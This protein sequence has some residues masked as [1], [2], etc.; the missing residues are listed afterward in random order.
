MPTRLSMACLIGAGALVLVSSREASTS[1]TEKKP[2]A[3]DAAAMEDLA[4]LGAGFLVWE[5][6]VGGCW[7]IWTRSL[8]G[9]TPESRLVSEEE[10]KDHFCPKISPD[11]KRMAYMSYAS[12][13]TP[14]DPVEGALWLIDLHTQKRKLLAERARSYQGDR[15]VLWVDAVTLCHIDERG[16]SIELNVE[17]GE[18]S[19]LTT[20]ARAKNGWLVNAQR[21]HATSGDA[22]FSTFDAKSGEVRVLPKHS[23]CQPYFSADGRWGF[24]MG[25][26]GGP[27]N[28]IFLPTRRVEPV[29][30]HND[31]RLP[32]DRNYVYFPMLSPCQRLMAF[33]ASSD[34]HDHYESDYDIFVIRVDRE[35]LEPIGAAVRYTSHPGNDRYP[36]VYCAELPLG[37][38]H[39][40]A[41]ARIRMKSPSGQSCA[42]FVDGV[43]VGVGSEMDH[44]FTAPG[45]HWMEARD[46]NTG[47]ELGRGFVQVRAATAPK[48]TLARRV[49]GDALALTFDQAVSL[50]QATATTENGKSIPFGAQHAER[51]G[52]LLPLTNAVQ[53]GSR[54]TLE[55]VRDLAQ[56]PNVMPR[57]SFTVPTTGWPQS[58]MGL[59]YA[60][61]HR[62]ALPMALTDA[63]PVRTG[64]AFWNMR[65]GMDV[66]GGAFEIPGAG[67]AMLHAC[68]K[69]G[70]FTLEAIITPMVPPYDREA[71]PVLSLEDSQGNVK[72]AILQ[73][74]SDWSLWLATEDNPRGTSIEQELL[75]LRTGQPHHVVVA[76]VQG[77]LQVCLNG[78][79]MSVPS[80]VHGALKFDTE[81]GV[82]RIGACSKLQNRW[83]GMVDQLSIYHRVLSPD[84]A[85]A[86]ADHAAQKL[87]VQR[88]ARTRKVVAR[89]VQSS[90]LPSLAEVA[91]YR[92]ALV[93][94]LYEVLPKDKD[95]RD[96]DFPVGSRI[97]VTQWVWVNGEAVHVPVAKDG[98]YRLF[99]QP[100]EMHREIQPLVIKSDLPA[101]A[102][103]DSWL[104]ISNW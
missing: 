14:T 22:E 29:L 43:N 36:D 67:S 66:R 87:E 97:V 101:D 59:V 95:D 77:R 11:G 53:P 41:P 82:L 38:H 31:P 81:E 100:T 88:Q 3:L 19:Q 60:W 23:G 74:R 33:A 17:T 44:E 26:S 56:R 91:P 102:P 34:N 9:R 12:G 72:L 4:R 92:E 15:A 8:D 37:S 57:T 104:E 52:A 16:H 94:H 96:Q 5:R 21:T 62:D 48:L 51:H 71:R 10:G 46:A 1:S 32:A 63:V 49:E 30:G 79:A 58:G 6:K 90:R 99:V 45:A 61:E 103:V 69:S 84:E 80:E 86:H 70:A 73:R 98:V 68:G 13:S 2:E 85:V 35:T 27:L 40:E 75:P 47:K 25:G 65:G 24:W 7:Q 20:K 28:K 76:Y 78:M 89:L 42:W 55:C 18:R 64:K 50:E 39:V 93:Q 83:Q 54:I